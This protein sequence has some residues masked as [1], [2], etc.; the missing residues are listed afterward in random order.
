M[1]TLAPETT[2][3]TTLR[4]LPERLDDRESFDDYRRTGGFAD[5]TWSLSP[6]QLID[7]IEASGLLGRGGSF[8]PTGTKLRSVAAKPGRHVVLV[9]GAESEPASKKDLCLMLLRP[10][11]VLEGALL[12]AHAVGADEVVVYVHDRRAKDSIDL[13]RREL[14]QAGASL[15]KLRT[16]VAPPSYVAGEQSAAVQWING[17]DAKPTIKPPA[18]H[19]KGVAGRPTLVQ[20]VETLASLALIAREGAEWFRSAG[21]PS[22]PG[23][24][25]ITLNGAIRRPG[26][27]EIPTG[28]TLEQV[29]TEYGGGL[30]DGLQAVLPGGYFAGW[31]APEQIWR[32]IRLDRESMRAAGVGLGSGAITVIPDNVC[33]LWQAVRLLRFFAEESARQCGPCTFGTV[34]MADVLQ[35]IARGTPETHDLER[36][37]HY[38]NHMLPKRGACSHLDG[39]TIMA[40]TAFDVFQREIQTHLRHGGCGRPTQSI[41]P[42]LESNH[43]F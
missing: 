21:S 40:R 34:A 20:N 31:L 38:A 13:A 9:N 32:G 27:Y 30:P 18:A 3:T 10:H 14:A 23:T 33:G 39:A 29:L 37:E 42:G 22:L 43:E 24:L 5:T 11:L 16:V 4:L 28:I 25:L 17:H 26:V 36:L 15:P 2:R 8:F 6:A 12:A 1:V 35:R 41:L 7:R 19:E